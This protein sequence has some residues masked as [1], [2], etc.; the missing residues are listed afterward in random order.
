[1]YI[2]WGTKVWYIYI[3][4]VVIKKQINKYK[5]ICLVKY[6]VFGYQNTKK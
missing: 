1:M 6:E 3:N 4:S 5:N 2:Y